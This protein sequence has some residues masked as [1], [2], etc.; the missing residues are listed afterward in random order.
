MP[1]K[2]KKRRNRRDYPANEEAGGDWEATKEEQN[3]GE[4]E[5]GAG[6]KGWRRKIIPASTQG[7]LQ[8]PV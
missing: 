7:F 3:R 2:A 8:T 1:P 4:I 6:M 5:E